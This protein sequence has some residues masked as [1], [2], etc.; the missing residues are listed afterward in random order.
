MTKQ[1]AHF[2]LVSDHFN[3][4]LEANISQTLESFEKFKKTQKFETKHRNLLWEHHQ[5][6]KINVATI[7]LINKKLFRNTLVQ[8]SLYTS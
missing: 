6:S 2:R 4:I 1:I 8:L 3:F 7:K 5:Q